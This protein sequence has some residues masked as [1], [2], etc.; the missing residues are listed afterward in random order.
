MTNGVYASSSGSRKWASDVADDAHDE[1]F[2]CW[3]RADG[4][5]RNPASERDLVAEQPAGQRLAHDDGRARRR[6]GRDRLGRREDPPEQ[7]GQ[8]HGAEVVVRHVVLADV[9]GLLAV[10]R[11]VQHPRAVAATRR[12]PGAQACAAERGVSRE[13]GHEIAVERHGALRRVAV[14]A[15]VEEM[16]AHAAG[17]EPNVGRADVAQ[18]DDE[19]RRVGHEGERQRELRHREAGSHPRTS[20]GRPRPVPANRCADALG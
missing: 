19:Q 11:R 7:H 3:L 15:E 4:R 9:D 13:A 18:R 20:G 12:N 1:A 5:K 14:A 6:R 16:E 2:V 17:I 10:P 8:P